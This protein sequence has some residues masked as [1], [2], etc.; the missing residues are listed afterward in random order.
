[1]INVA[2]PPGFAVNWLFPRLLNFD[3]DHP[4]TPV[5][6]STQPGID[7][8]EDGGIDVG[9]RYAPVR[10]AGLHAERLLSERVFP[11]CHPAL[12]TA[13]GGLASVADLAHQTLLADIHG[14]SRVRP[15]TWEFWADETGQTLPRPARIRRFGQSNLS[16]QAAIQGA[17]VALGREP[18]V[19]DAL[20]SGALVTPLPYVAQSKFHYWFV[21]SPRALGSGPI[22]EFRDWLHREAAR[23][24]RFIPSG[25]RN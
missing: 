6:I 15:P 19:I 2:C 25:D 4:D 16:L 17:G 11:V 8:S 7:V 13:E 1:M 5:S 9:I 22:R 24:G 23:Q 14:P 10:P 18:L 20:R 12:V 21:C 3:H